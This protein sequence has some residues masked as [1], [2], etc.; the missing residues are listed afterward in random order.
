MVGYIYIYIYLALFVVEDILIFA[1]EVATHN[2][3]SFDECEN[4]KFRI[5]GLKLCKCF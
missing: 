1:F 4:T 5:I 2:I 3:C